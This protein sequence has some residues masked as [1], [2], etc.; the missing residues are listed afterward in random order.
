MNE[1]SEDDG[2]TIEVEFEAVVSESEEACDCGCEE[3]SHA[4]G[5]ACDCGCEEH[6]HAD[7]EQPKTPTA[8]VVDAVASAAREVAGA[9]KEAYK[10][11]TEKHAEEKAEEAAPEDDKAE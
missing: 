1:K 2:E 6:S 4:D 7:G 5:E 3:H 9:V 10:D 8:K 11:I